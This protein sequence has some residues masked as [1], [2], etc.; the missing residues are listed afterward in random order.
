MDAA[1]R[2]QIPIIQEYLNNALTEMR[3]IAAGL[4][5]PQLESLTLAEVFSR[6]V[7]SHERRTGTKVILDAADLPEQASLPVKITIYRIVQ[8]ALNNA[9]RHAAG[10][11][12]Q[13][14]AACKA[15]QLIIEVSDHGP[16]FDVT[17]PIDW[18]VHLGMA[19]M[20]ERVESLGGIFRVES[21]I[22]RGTKIVAMLTIQEPGAHTDE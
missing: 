22:N 4:G 6:V 1:S 8:E 15:S 19:G 2:E 13:V 17:K 16:G 12:Q 11:G 21:E 20:R 9:H 18:D 14:R 5:V 7:R 3:A 10:E